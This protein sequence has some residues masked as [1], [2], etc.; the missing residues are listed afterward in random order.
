MRRSL[1]QAGLSKQAIDAAWPTW[2]SDEASGDAS[3]RAEL[4]FALARK[5][6][7]SPKGLLGERVEFVWNDDAK[8]KHLSTENPEQRAA[9]AS[10][11]VSLGRLLIRT[12]PQH[13]D[14]TNFDASAIRDIILAGQQ[15]VDLPGLLAFC[16]GIGIP[17]VHLRVLPL[18]TKS[19]HAMVVHIKG[20]YA[21]LLGRD[22]NYLAPAAFTLAHELGHIF[23]SHLTE[24]P[25]LV[26]LK[27]PALERDADEQEREADEFALQLLTGRSAPEIT[28]SIRDFNAPTL[29]A[30]VL[31][32][33]P[34][35][36]IEPGTLALCLAHQQGAWARAMS[37]LKFI[38]PKA[39][40]VWT[41]IN[42]IASKQL[43]FDKISLEN[44]DYLYK[45]MGESV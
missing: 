37:A 7:V 30:A 1:R 10:F 20:R 29:A 39:A 28:T 24:A 26:D 44:A 31:R 43:D 34:S 9:L 27:D 3:G 16:W 45:V 13:T 22:A 11:G 6:G 40:P 15:Y 17:V 21:V 18:D 4:R 2:W 12:A 35:Y 32:A 14:L 33:A 38:Y 8:F 25:A 36:R 5:L 19:M 23:R 42:T 41:L